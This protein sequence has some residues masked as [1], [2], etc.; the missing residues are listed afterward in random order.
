MSRKEEYKEVDKSQ[1]ELRIVIGSTNPVKSRAVA[2]ACK[3]VFPQ[4][5]ILVQ[6]A[7][8][9]SGVPSQPRDD[10][11]TKHGAMNRALHAAAFAQRNYKEAAHF[12][13]GIEG[14][15]ADVTTTSPNCPGQEIWE[16]FAW[17]AVLDARGRWGL[18]RTATVQLP[19]PLVQ[20]LH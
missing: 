9:H 5:Q 16:C 10:G 19:T 18:S 8:V 17:I 12:S 15:V 4:E 13:V 1:G 7:N 20:L 2:E 11:T 6:E 3:K 14:G